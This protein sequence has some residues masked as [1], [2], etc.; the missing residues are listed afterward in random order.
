MYFAK[1][2]FIDFRTL[3]AFYFLF[4]VKTTALLFCKAG[5]ILCTTKFVNTELFRYTKL[6][7][8]NKPDVDHDPFDLCI[9]KQS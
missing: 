2:D 8:G 1:V 5:M 4:S 7:M 3:P 9:N 6:K